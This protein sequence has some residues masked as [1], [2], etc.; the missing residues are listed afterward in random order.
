MKHFALAVLVVLSAAPVFPTRADE[1][2]TK[3]PRY[4]KDGQLVRPT[5]YREWIYLSS[6]LGMNY[7]DSPRTEN[8]HFDNV[9]VQPD[10]YRAFL[11]TGHWPDK[12]LFVLEIRASGQHGSI[13]RD[14]HF[15]TDLVALEAEVKDESRYP[16]K[17]AFFSFGQAASLLDSTK[18]FPANSVCNQCHA[19]N[20]AVDNTFVQFYP[21]LL[22][23]AKA[24]GTLR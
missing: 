22:E 16:H 9:F 20:A 14:G 18:P 24:K 8:P 4:T 1:T 19:K 12:T 3:D 7:S 13:N 10:A 17:W 5:N 11:G 23:V 15:Q 2:A 21:T 6:G